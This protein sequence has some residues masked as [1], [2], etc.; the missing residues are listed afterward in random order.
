MWRSRHTEAQ[1]IGALKQVE[2][3]RA[4]EDVAFSPPRRFGC[5]MVFTEAVSESLDF[6]AKSKWGDLSVEESCR[7]LITLFCGGNGCRECLCRV[8]WRSS[9]WALYCAQ[10]LIQPGVCKVGGES[11]SCF[12]WT[13]LHDS[14]FLSRNAPPLWKRRAA[15]G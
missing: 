10:P 6:W 2:A 12:C 5:G 9:V 15:M 13:L 14:Q 11:R 8:S 1:I 3:G 4:V 7:G